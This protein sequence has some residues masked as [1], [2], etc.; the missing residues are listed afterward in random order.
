MKPLKLTMTAF[1]SYAGTQTIDFRELGD[2]SFFLIHGPTGS[3]KTT[4]LDAICFALYGQPSG[5]RVGEQ[6]RSQHTKTPLATEVTFDF[7]LGAKKYRVTRHPKQ[8]V[9]KKR[10]DGMQTVTERVTLWDRTNCH[11]EQAEGHVIASAARKVEAEVETLFGFK[12]NEFLQVMMLPQDKFRELLIADSAKREGI[13]KT[14]FQTHLYEQIENELKAREKE[15]GDKIKELKQQQQN[16]FR[17]GGVETEAA[18]QARSEELG[19]L[20]QEVR[21]RL[22]DLLQA[23]K[24]AQEDFE[25][26]HVIAA[27][28]AETEEAESARLEL[29]TQQTSIDSQRRILAQARQASVLSGAEQAL[30]QTIQHSRDLVQKRKIAEKELQV[31]VKIQQTTALALEKEEQR[32]EERKAARQNVDHLET[33]RTQVEALSEAQAQFKR[34]QELFNQANNRRD[35][36]KRS[37]TKLAEQFSNAQKLLQQT[38]KDSAQLNAA[39]IEYKQIST[40]YDQRKKLDILASDLG[41]A[42]NHQLECDTARDKAESALS[43]AREHVREIEEAWLQEQ[44][45][46][47]ASTLMDGEPCPVCGSI[48]H[49]LPAHATQSAI[50]QKTLE[51][52]RSLVAQH[53]TALQTRRRESEKHSIAVSTLRMQINQIKEALDDYTNVPLAEMM[54][55][56]D[57][58]QKQ[59]DHLKAQSE[60]LRPRT[61]KVHSLQADLELAEAELATAE[62][63]Y[64][65]ANRTVT[66]ARVLVDER[67]RDVPEEFRDKEKLFL[68]QRK[69]ADQVRILELALA[70]A[71]QAANKA[72]VDAGGRKSGFEALTNL[73]DTAVTNAANQ[74]EEFNTR[75]FQAGFTMLQF[76]QDAKRTEEEIHHI[77]QEIT[78]FGKALHSAEQRAQHAREQSAGLLP[79]DLQALNAAVTQA[80]KEREDAVRA[81]E[82]CKRELTL[83]NQCLEEIAELMVSLSEKQERY[84]IVGELASVANG[85]NGY[86]LTFQRFVLSAKLNDVLNEASKR[87]Q[88][89]SDGRYSVQIQA[90]RQKGIKASG[91]DIE[92]N[93][94]WTGKTRPVNTLSG[95]ESFYTSLA[96]AL[97]LADVVQAYSGGIRLDTIF[98]DEGF[99]SLDAEKLDQ[100]IQTLENLKEGGRLVG[101]ISHVDSLRERIPAR[102][103]VSTSIHGSTAQFVLG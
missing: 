30:T 20:V 8:E 88:L 67:G 62:S 5:E 61:A 84:A 51:E 85:R 89:V 39:N 80:K 93:D 41:N 43:A 2:R 68:A 33:L 19:H 11:D 82:G 94:S 70:N 91:L 15:L 73:A 47:L 44:S 14:L 46:L 29:A 58:L 3:G 81:E 13:F 59:V 55:T 9:P 99:G 17:R 76:Y 72:N 86:N 65:E 92:V 63:E 18:L 27:K 90:E 42:V 24:R 75:V 95:G 71:R 64:E 22:N 103:E 100:A 101:I 35:G 56:R 10:G 1:G 36:S 4:I 102:L 45:A 26:G 31:A 60:Q 87:L 77:D 28:I 6:M 98:V 32:E 7:E 52:S 66:G 57:T 49:P 54:S 69:A 50:T 38:E 48:H 83:V 21:E 53:E 34:A 96:L 16:L 78:D 23:E 37:K 79:P 25:Q 12:R 74:E 40:A 97:G